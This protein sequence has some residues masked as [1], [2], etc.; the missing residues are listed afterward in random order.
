MK[1]DVWSLLR[2]MSTKKEVEGEKQWYAQRNEVYSGEKRVKVE[3]TDE[4]VEEE[5]DEDEYGVFTTYKQEETDEEETDEEV[6]ADP[7][8]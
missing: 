2:S 5:T 4:G 3:E 6:A 1:K 8:M 7:Y